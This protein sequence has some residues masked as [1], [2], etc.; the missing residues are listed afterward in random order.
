ME[1]RIVN[2]VQESGLLTIDL[3][4]FL[5]QQSPASFDLVPFLFKG[6]LLREKDFREAMAQHDWQQYSGQCVAVHCSTDAII[7]SWSYMLVSFR[8]SGIARA[9]YLGT[10]AEMEKQLLLEEI[11]AYDF[12]AFTDQ[13]VVVKGC[14]DRE[15]PAFAFMEVTTRLAPIVK[16]LMYG[17][18]CSTVPIFKRKESGH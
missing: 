14:G 1:T 12:S 10:P 4:I 8:L 13:R 5:P 15:T 16:S 6:L 18:P 7:P 9:T 11:A 17:E 2:K 3:G